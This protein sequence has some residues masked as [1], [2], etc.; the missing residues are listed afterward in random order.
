LHLRD[1]LDDDRLA[2]E[3]GSLSSRTIEQIPYEQ[4]ASV[5]ATADVRF[6]GQSHE[7]NVRVS[8]PDLASIREAFLTDYRREY[9]TV[10]S[11]RQI[12]I[13][14]LRLR[15]IGQ[16]TRIAL[17]DAA[18]EAP[19]ERSMRLV[20]PGGQEV[21]CS[22]VNRAALNGGRRGP[23]LILDPEATTFVPPGWLAQR[24]SAG[25]VRLERE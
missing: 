4:T 18:G 6:L 15:R 11:N 10:P 13:V 21:P 22:A 20:N 2:A 25:S 1:Q 16:G 8:S 17:P 9:G 23:L 12:E 5:E 24:T 14:T 3:Y 7:L 19:Q